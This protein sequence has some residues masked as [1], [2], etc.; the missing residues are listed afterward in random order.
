[1]PFMMPMAAAETQLPEIFLP[2]LQSALKEFGSAAAKAGELEGFA[3]AG[4]DSKFV[5]ANAKADGGKVIVW[6]DEIAEPKAVHYSFAGNPKGNL[7][8][9]AGLPASPFSSG[10]PFL[11]GIF[12]VSF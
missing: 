12:F 8:N 1:M 5:W 2:N 3:I 10:V 7:V 4:A 6:H 9:G 11:S